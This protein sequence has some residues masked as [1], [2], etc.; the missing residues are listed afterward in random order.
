MHLAE[1]QLQ[2]SRAVRQ[3]AAGL[4][5]DESSAMLAL[6]VLDRPERMGVYQELVFNN[7]KTFVD[8]CF[9]VA[10]ACLGES[11]WLALCQGFV[12]QHRCATPFFREIPREFVEWIEQL[13]EQPHNAS[14][15][16]NLPAYLPHLLHYEWLELCVQ[17]HA[18]SDWTSAPIVV[19]LG[20]DEEQILHVR[21]N[22]TVQLAC[23][24]YAVHKIAP[25]QSVSEEPTCLMVWRDGAFQVQFAV[26]HVASYLLLENLSTLDAADGVGVIALANPI[27]QVLGAPVP[28]DNVVQEL[29]R[30]QGLGVV[31]AA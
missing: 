25:E 14:I 23:Y 3:S 26:L 1:F 19:V 29:L 7:I 27:T 28:A 16:F 21:V 10:A 5:G 9:P 31:G 4:D 11:T 13:Y 6:S 8:A 30:L 12:T 2:F 20:R 24:P 18:N 17:T 15:H 22:P